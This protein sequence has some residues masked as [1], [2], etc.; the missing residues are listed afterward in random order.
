[1]ISRIFN[2]LV[3]PFCRILVVLAGL[4]LPVVNTKSLED[5]FYF[6]TDDS[7]TPIT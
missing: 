7:F 3:S 4:T 2:G 6:I 5:I 1:M